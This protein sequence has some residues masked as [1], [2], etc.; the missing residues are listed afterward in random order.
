[1]GLILYKKE[2]YKKGALTLADAVNVAQHAL[3]RGQQAEHN[4]K[5]YTPM[6]SVLADIFTSFCLLPLDTRFLCLISPSDSPRASVPLGPRLRAAA[7]GAETPGPWVPQGA[8]VAPRQAG[9]EGRG[10]RA[11][12]GGTGVCACV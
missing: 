2:A 10:G 8:R 6:N 4:V 3:K 9:A 5:C 12:E 11:D 1:M 7:R